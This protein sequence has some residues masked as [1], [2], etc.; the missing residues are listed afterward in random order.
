ME[1]VY[2]NLTSVIIRDSAKEI[3]RNIKFTMLKNTIYTIVGKNGHGKSTLINA[4]TNLH[5]PKH[6]AVKGKALFD[7]ANLLELPLNEL[8]QLRKSKIQ[9]VFQDPINSFDP[10]KNIGYYFNNPLFTK[11]K[12]DDA[13][14]Y[15]R[16]P[17]YNTISNLYPYELSGGMAQRI[18]FILA[19]LKEPEFLILDEPTSGIDAETILLIKDYLK[20]YIK[21]GDRII[22]LVTQDLEFA[23]G[24]TN[25]VALI[26]DNTLSEFE[27]FEKFINDAA[28]TSAR[29]FINAYK[30][31]SNG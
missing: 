15:F 4:I 13:L 17:A 24:L 12:I 1:K 22:L 7:D 19:I 14:M 2:I 23:K 26:S 27:T 16:L 6:F 8:Q 5:N 31:L 10:L 11:S 20:S 18:A 25:L 30:E 29:V 28:D 3:L 21:E 9:Y